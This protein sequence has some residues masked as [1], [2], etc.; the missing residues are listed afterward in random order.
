MRDQ[1]FEYELYVRDQGLE[2]IVLVEQ[3]K[4]DIQNYIPRI[5]LLRLME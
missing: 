5:I 1:G 2:F 4:Y 3:R